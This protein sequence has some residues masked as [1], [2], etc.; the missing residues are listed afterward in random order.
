MITLCCSRVIRSRLGVEQMQAVAP[1]PTTRLGNWYVHLV[2]LGSR[3]Y[4]LATSERSLLSVILPARALRATLEENLRGAVGQLLSALS[5]P[6]EVVSRELAQMQQVLIAPATN[7]L[8][9][10]SMN[11][12]AFHLGVRQDEFSDLVEMA[13]SLSGIPMSAVG[14]KGRYGISRDVAGD[15]LLSAGA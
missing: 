13:L 9:L 14:S 4:V 8:V 15:L 6:M 3:Q 5:I 10:G 7:R 12:L 1:E 2:R 11:E